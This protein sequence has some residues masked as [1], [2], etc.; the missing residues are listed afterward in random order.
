MNR[1]LASTGCLMVAVFAFF[2]LNRSGPLEAGHTP[3]HVGR[4]HLVVKEHNLKNL[5]AGN[6][7]QMNGPFTV[8]LQER[9]R[10]GSLVPY[11]V[12]PDRVFVVTDAQG[13]IS[14][15]SISLGTVWLRASG[16]RRYPFYNSRSF[17]LHL[18]G[19]IA[20]GPDSIIEVELP[21]TGS[22][23]T[24]EIEILGYETVDL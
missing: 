15:N 23:L 13:R 12:P 4:T 19:G 22:P 14:T 6:V 2:L 9:D 21:A 5:T 8:T 11:R 10:F 1:T 3:G 18:T 24:V 20:F 16:V 17:D 7:P